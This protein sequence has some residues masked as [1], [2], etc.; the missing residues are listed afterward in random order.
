MNKGKEREREVTLKW[1]LFVQGDTIKY[2]KQSK[3]KYSQFYRLLRVYIKV[4]LVSISIVYT[5]D[6]IFFFSFEEYFRVK[7]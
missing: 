2:G 7:G 5:N 1:T 3:N 6:Q 4:P